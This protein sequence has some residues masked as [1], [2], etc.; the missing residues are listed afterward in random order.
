MNKSRHHSYG[1]SAFLLILLIGSIHQTLIANEGSIPA[2]LF[3]KDVRPILKANCFHCH[4]EG[5][6]LHSGL[7]MRLRRLLVQGGNA[8][9]AIVP[10]KPAESLLLRLLKN[11]Q[12]PPPKIEKRLTSAEMALIE[13]WIASGANTADVE[14]ETIE[15]G[16]YVTHE[17]RRFWSFQPLVRTAPPLVKQ[18]QRV[19]TPIDQFVLAQL[20]DKGLGF[21]PDA[22]QL[23]ILRRLYLDLTGLPPTVEDVDLSLIHISA[24]TRRPPI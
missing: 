15:T 18:H 23:T 6:K 8:G 1:L 5:Q 9:P 2:P 16:F 4:G 20:E 13:Q 12:M 21:A 3:E 10:G 17:E 11:G 22:D 19:R 14:P 24:P 7:D